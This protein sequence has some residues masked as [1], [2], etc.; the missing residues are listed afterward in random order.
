MIIKDAVNSGQLPEYH[1]GQLIVKM[2]PFASPMGIVAANFS[3]ASP[4]T[5]PGMSALSFFE[6]AGLIKRIIPLATPATTE[7]LPAG[8]MSFGASSSAMSMLAASAQPPTADDPNAG[9]SIIEL[10]RDRDVSDLQIALAQDPN[11]EFVSR[12]PVRYLHIARKKQTTKKDDNQEAAKD[13]AGANLGG[14]GIMA[15]PPPASTMWNLQKIMWQQARILPNFRDANNIK[16]AVLDTGI[17]Q[18]HPDL[19]GRIAR[20]LFN[21]TGIPSASSNRDIIGHGTHVA[22]TIAA[23]VVNNVGING[24]CNCRLH[25]YK[26]FDDTPDFDSRSGEFVYFV[27]TAMYHRALAECIQQR[28]DVV[29]KS[30]RTSFIQH[31]FSKRNNRCRLNGQFPPRW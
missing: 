5:T 29:N 23:L 1:E 15:V 12:V 25:A 14:A 28:V 22:G 8:T 31:A 20:Y 6:N 11:V 19:S 21:Y 16:V 2:R 27:D 30:A 24:I 7:D 17:E 10:Q 4:L 26:I 18:L 9:V 13:S 3:P